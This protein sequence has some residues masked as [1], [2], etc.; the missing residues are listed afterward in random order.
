MLVSELDGFL[1]GII[2]C[3]DP[4][5]PGKWLPMVWGGGDEDRSPVFNDLAQVEKIT[6]L[7]MEHY[8]GT[9]LALNEGRYAPVFDIDPRNDEIL[10]AFWIDG[11]RMAMAL[12]FESWLKI[13]DGDALTALSGLVALDAISRGESGLPDTEIDQLT[14]FAPDLISRWVETLHTSR[15]GQLTANQPQ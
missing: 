9:I 4:I 11:F 13:T 7:I 5:M 10:W 15:L 8:N 3:P 6:G 12:R 2:I 1:A 14:E